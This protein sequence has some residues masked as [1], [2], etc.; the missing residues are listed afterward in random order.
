MIKKNR[1]KRLFFDIETSPNIGFFWQAG[2]EIDVDTHN[3]ITER[4]IICI[5]WKWEGDKQIYSLKWDNNQNDKKMIQEFVK[6]MHDADEVVGH[7]GD[8]F[9]IRWIRT[10][11]ILHKIDFP[12]KII[13]IDT[14]KNCRSLFKMNSNKLDYVA[15]YLGIGRKIDT[16][17]FDTWRK[18]ILDKDAQALKHMIEYCKNDVVILE[19]LWNRL[20]PYVNP[21]T[22]AGNYTNE[23]PE[24]GKVKLK[25]S[26]TIKLA[27]GYTRHQMKCSDCGKYHTLT[28][29]KL[30]KVK[31]I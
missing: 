7:N 24:C 4:A 20:N 5:C 28:P 18:I 10:R 15:Q 13:S 9:D 2:Y 16:G 21:K 14:L 3:I 31:P 23:C 29:S 17:G 27:S 1:R 11:A 22:H 6:V 12:P 8:R 26:K 30:I 19:K 25:I